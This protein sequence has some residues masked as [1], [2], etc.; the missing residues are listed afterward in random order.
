VLS[1]GSVG[2]VV[3]LLGYGPWA[4][5]WQALTAATISSVLLWAMSPWRPS[6]AF[7][8][9]SARRLGSFGLRSLGGKMFWIL[10]E[11]ADNVLIGRYLGAAAAGRYPL[12]YNLMLAHAGRVVAPIQ[13][14]L[15]LL[16]RG[17]RKSQSVWQRDGFVSS[18]R[19]RRPAFP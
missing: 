15:F 19:S 6:F 10:T 4:L 16:F 14:V 2:V 5:I 1:G 7:S 13:E 3:A 12:A 9:S 18:A 8:L 17:C 11:N